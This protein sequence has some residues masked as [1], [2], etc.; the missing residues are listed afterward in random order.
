[1]KFLLYFCM[2]FSLP[3]A[4]A[5]NLTPASPAYSDDECEDFQK[6]ASEFI[7][8]E[9]AG[10]RWQGA[11]APAC[12]AKLKPEAT[13]VDRVPASDPSLLDPEFLIPDNRKVDFSVRRLPGD[14]LEVV[15]H[16][17]GKKNKTDVPVKDQFLLKLNFGKARETRGCASWYTEPLHFAMRSHCWRD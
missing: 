8:M 9:L 10:L 12:L 7:T 15:M 1:L 3:F 4:R 5:E 14:L 6:I 16:Y 2:F 13:Q 11:E 17:L